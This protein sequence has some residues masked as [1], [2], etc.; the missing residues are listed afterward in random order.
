MKQRIW[1][2]GDLRLLVVGLAFVVAWAGIGYR[3]FDLQGTQ[4]VALASVGYDQRIRTQAIDP[5][6]GTI[7]D[8]DGIEMAMTVD[9]WNIVVDPQLIDDPTAAAVVLAPYTDTDVSILAAELQDAQ[10]AGSRYAEIVERVRVSTKDMIELAVKE[11]DIGGVFYRKQPLRV[12]PAGSIAS[13]IIGLT[14]NDDGA[15]LEGLER[16]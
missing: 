4:A 13:Q 8:R 9:G 16:T 1:D 5:P 12:Y 2:R 15:G 14:R 7:Y 11:A 10:D 6:R 3:L